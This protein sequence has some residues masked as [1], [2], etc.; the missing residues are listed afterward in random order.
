MTHASRR[1]CLTNIRYLVL[2]WLNIRKLYHGHQRKF[3]Q[4]PQQS[5]YCTNVNCKSPQSQQRKRHT[6]YREHIT[7]KT[8]CVWKLWTPSKPPFKRFAWIEI[9]TRLLEIL[10][11]LINIHSVL[12]LVMWGKVHF[13]WRSKRTTVSWRNSWHSESG[14]SNEHSFAD[15]MFSILTLPH[16]NHR[17]EMDQMRSQI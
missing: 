10:F 15:K 14:G 13:F 6:R 3:V 5:L 1:R 17:G 12:Q 4:Q 7:H 9:F 8:I 11:K 2:D 16:P